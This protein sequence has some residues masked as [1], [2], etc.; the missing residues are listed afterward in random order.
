MSLPWVLLFGHSLINRILEPGEDFSEEFRNKCPPSLD[1]SVDQCHL[2]YEGVPGG[3][4][5]KLDERDL[6]KSMNNFDV[7]VAQIAGNDVKHIVMS[8]LEIQ[9][10]C[11]K[12]LNMVQRLLQYVSVVVLCKLFYRK[13]SLSRSSRIRCTDHQRNYN[14][15]VDKINANLS[16]EL[17]NET[18]IYLWRTKGQILNGLSMLGVDGTHFNEDGHYKYWRSLRGAVLHGLAMLDGATAGREPPAVKSGRGQRGSSSPAVTPTGSNGGPTSSDAK[19][20]CSEWGPSTTPG[21][22]CRTPTKS[23]HGPTIGPR[24]RSTPKSSD[25]PRS[26]REY[27]NTK[28]RYGSGFD[29]KSRHESGSTRKRNRP[30]SAAKPRHQSGATRKSTVSKPRI[31]PGLQSTT[32]YE[33]GLQP[34]SN[35]RPRLQPQ[36]RYGPGQQPKPR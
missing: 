26:G 11:M 33:S 16:Y 18:N 15:N 10:I 28:S 22:Y 27:P 30:G 21:S 12:T 20:K 3:T 9:G 2:S 24:P 8:N 23:K 36:P 17:K 35:D 1:L 14:A 32:R 19:S 5:K 34:E 25:R 31:G 4:L 13:A 29:A 7:V 6:W